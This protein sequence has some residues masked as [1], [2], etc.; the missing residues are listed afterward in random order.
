MLEDFE[1]LDLRPSS[2][3]PEEGKVAADTIGDCAYA[4]LERAQKN[5]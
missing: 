5:S 1:S 4:G 2:I 3:Q